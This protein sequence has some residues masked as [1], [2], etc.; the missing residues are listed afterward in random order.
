MSGDYAITR[1][2]KWR[3]KMFC[4]WDKM[5]KDE[6]QKAKTTESC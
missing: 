2:N 3:R 4:G 1:D 5:P 6:P